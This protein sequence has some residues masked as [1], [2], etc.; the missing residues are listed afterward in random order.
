MLLL[1]IINY[2]CT[3]INEKK[4]CKFVCTV[5]TPSDPITS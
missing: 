4:D 1:K 3:C 2:T 5:N